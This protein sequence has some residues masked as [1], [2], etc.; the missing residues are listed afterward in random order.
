LKPVSDTRFGDDRQKTSGI[1]GQLPAQIADRDAQQVNGIPILCAAPDLVDELKVSSY[2]S[3]VSNQDI[4]QMILGRGQP[5]LLASHENRAAIEV[6][7]QIPG[8]EHIARHGAEGSS[9]R[10]S[11]SRQQFSHC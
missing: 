1:Y 7:S 11:N 9:E 8:C 2:P 6:Y 4:E 3:R 5:H 10:G